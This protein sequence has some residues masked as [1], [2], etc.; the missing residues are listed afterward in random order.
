MEVSPLTAVDPKP[1]IQ[2]LAENKPRVSDSV[3]SER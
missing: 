2:F 1:D 3:V